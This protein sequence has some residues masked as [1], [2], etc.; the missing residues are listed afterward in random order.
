MFCVQLSP[1]IVLESKV[2]HDQ[3]RQLKVQ[4]RFTKVTVYRC[5]ISWPK[6]HLKMLEKFIF[7]ILTYDDLRKKYTFLF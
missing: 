6:S 7:G 2:K 4:Q 5:K 1:V 3:L